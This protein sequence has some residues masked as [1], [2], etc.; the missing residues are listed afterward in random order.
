[1]EYLRRHWGGS[2]SN[3]GGQQMESPASSSPSQESDAPSQQPTPSRSQ[4]PQPAPQQ[5]PSPQPPPLY[6][7]PGTPAQ[8][9]PPYYQDPADLIN[10]LDA[11]PLSRFSIQDQRQLLSILL[12]STFRTNETTEQI[13]ETLVEV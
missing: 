5:S 7:S 9:P 10:L 6:P 12:L 2:S 13:H 3:S 8:R 11:E 4:S 1:M